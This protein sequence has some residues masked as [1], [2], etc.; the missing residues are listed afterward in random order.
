[1]LVFIQSLNIERLG[2]LGEGKLLFFTTGQ[3]SLVTSGK[4]LG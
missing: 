3:L 1:M 2:V 4:F